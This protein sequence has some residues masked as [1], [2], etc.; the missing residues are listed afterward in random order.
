MFLS[1]GGSSFGSWSASLGNS[2][3]GKIFLTI[4]GIILFGVSVGWIIGYALRII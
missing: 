2:V 1:E 3:V 4:A